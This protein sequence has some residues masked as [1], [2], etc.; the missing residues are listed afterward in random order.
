MSIDYSYD[1]R[2][3]LR[4][5]TAEYAQLRIDLTNRLEWIAAMEEMVVEL[6]RQIREQGAELRV[7]S[8]RLE[9]GDEQ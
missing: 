1:G 9:R 2:A 4:R 5:L 7:L 3:A 8:A 6:Q